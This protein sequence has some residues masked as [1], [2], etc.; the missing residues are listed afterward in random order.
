VQRCTLTGGEG[1]GKGVLGGGGKEGG[2][3]GGGVLG[4][5]FERGW[6]EGMPGNSRLMGPILHATSEGQH[7]DHLLKGWSSG[8]KQKKRGRTTEEKER[9]GL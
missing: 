9:R 4:W 6:K 3:G 2:G 5:W 8:G 1:F 7:I